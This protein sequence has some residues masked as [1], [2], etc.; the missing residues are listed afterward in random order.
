MMKH[1]V[2]VDGNGQI[3]NALKA[4]LDCGYRVSFV[5]SAEFQYYEQS[6]QSAALLQQLNAVIVLPRTTDAELVYGALRTLHL[7]HPVDA[8]F[9]LLDLPIV[10]V[11]HAC[12]RMGVRFADAAALARARDKH[13]MRETLHASGI[14]SA[15][16]ARVTD[17]DAALSAAREIGY[18]VIL[19]PVSGLAS[20]AATCVVDDAH[21]RRAWESAEARISAFPEDVR[22]NLGGGLLIE[23]RLSGRMFSV[24]L[25]RRGSEQF[26]FM[27]SGRDRNA[28]DE[29]DVL[30]ITMPA[31]LD[32]QQSREA[33]AYANSV[34]DALGFEFG[35]FHIEMMWTKNG[36]R[37]IEVNPRPMGGNMPKLY[38]QLTGKS[39]FPALFALHLDEPVDHGI[40][41]NWGVVASW[42]MRT[43]APTLGPVKV[44]WRTLLNNDPDIVNVTW[45][46][47][48]A[49]D[50]AIQDQALLGRFQIRR[51]DGATAVA[52][53]R[54]LLAEV[55]RQA[56]IE[57]C[58][59][60]DRFLPADRPLTPA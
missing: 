34:L 58:Y 35:F 48:A 7:S 39:I 6:A 24:E 51:R 53:A 5:Q 33:V 12:H 18:P 26:L 42:R 4:A 29:T 13:T 10:A 30:G 41:P 20:I 49:T 52:D 37:L 57:L 2:F 38:E 55:E 50:G 17:L 32:P 46:P 25:A 44:D 31:L 28:F 19:K 23:E 40:D 21:L 36:P 8:V 1:L 3:F 59:P 56:G 60:S 11:S 45:D 16:S 43:A 22:R 9:S 27:L 54:R 47:L 15:R 14:P